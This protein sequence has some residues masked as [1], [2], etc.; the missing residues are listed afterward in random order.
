MDYD[1]TMLEPIKDRS[2][3]AYQLHTI[4]QEKG[5]PYFANHSIKEAIAEFANRTSLSFE[6]VVQSLIDELTQAFRVVLLTQVID[7][8]NDPNSHDTPRRLAKMYINE[9]FAGRYEL[10]PKITAF[11]ND[12][13]ADACAASGVSTPDDVNL[14]HFNNLLVVQAPFISVCSHHHA[15]VNGVAY[16]GIIPGKKLIGLSKYTRLVQ[17]LAARGTLQEELTIDIAAGIQGYT[18]TDDIGVVVFARHGCC[19]NRGIRVHN[20]NTSTA[21]MRGL[22]MRDGTLRKEFYDSVKMM[23]KEL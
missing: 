20:S 1:Y 19:E 18:E 3:I 15:P 5:I 9:L 11:P 7:I 22:F 6:D 13:P 12:K 2:P 21:E 10:P 23:R 4:L 17:H 8:K 14:F 16:I